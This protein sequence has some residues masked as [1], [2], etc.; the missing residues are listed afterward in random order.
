VWRSQADLDEHFTQPY[1]ADLLAAMAAPGLLVG[2]P[3][4][5]FTSPVPI[6]DPAKGRLA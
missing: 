3:S 4:M 6:G 1:L 5:W 2:R